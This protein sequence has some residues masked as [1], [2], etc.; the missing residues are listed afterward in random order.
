MFKR[1]KTPFVVVVGAQRR[2]EAAKNICCQS[3]VSVVSQTRDLESISFSDSDHLSNRSSHTTK[4]PS[5][6]TRKEK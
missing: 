6:Y 1:S 4:F 3:R 2:R 5:K